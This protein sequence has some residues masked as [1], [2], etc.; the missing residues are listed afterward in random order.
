MTRKK[1]V[2]ITDMASILF[3]RQEKQSS[4]ICPHKVNKYR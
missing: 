3:T 4:D 2:L 1:L